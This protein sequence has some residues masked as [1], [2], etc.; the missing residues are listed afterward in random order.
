[1]QIF[2]FFFIKI[3]FFNTINRKLCLKNKNYN[4]KNSAKQYK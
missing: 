4:L 1:M 3:A 2:D